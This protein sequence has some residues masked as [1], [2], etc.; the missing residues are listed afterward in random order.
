[1]NWDAL[2]DYDTENGL[3]IWKISGAKVTC[4]NGEG[5]VVVK[6]AQR[7]YKAHRII[8]DMLHPNSTLKAGEE[9][10]HINHK[11]DDNRIVNLR[12]VT[13]SENHRNTSRAS[14]N[15]SGITGIYWF[16]RTG[17]WKVQIKVEGKQIHLGYFDD[18]DA[19]RKARTD[20]EV[21]YG[22][23]TNHGVVL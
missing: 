17:K 6:V 5:Y 21:L 23:H 8:W 7:Q 11:R 22:F 1:M 10:D 2:F 9:I 3:L 12:K 14:N 13:K 16:K 15:K 20:A 19:A 4:V 18:I